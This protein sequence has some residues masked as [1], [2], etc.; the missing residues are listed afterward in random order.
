MVCADVDADAA[1][2]LAAKQA[3]AHVL[4]H[5]HTHRPADHDLGTA[6]ARIVLSDWDARGAAA[7]RCKP[8]RLSQRGRP[9]RRSVLMFGWLRKLRA[10]RAHP[11][12]ASGRPC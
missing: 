10:P 6:C 11:G 3:G 9:A 7:A 5:G 12:R 8:L 2:R 1:T 4:V